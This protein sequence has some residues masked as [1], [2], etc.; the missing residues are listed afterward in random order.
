MSFNSHLKKSVW[1]TRIA[2]ITPI[3][4]PL[5]N[6]RVSIEG[7]S[8]LMR[9]GTM[10]PNIESPQCCHPPGSSVLG[11][12]DPRRTET[13]ARQSSTSRLPEPTPVTVYRAVPQVP[14]PLCS[15]MWLH[16]CSLNNIWP[17]P[18]YPPSLQFRVPYTYVF[19]HLYILGCMTFARI[20]SSA[21]QK[22]L[23]YISKHY[24]C[25]LRRALELDI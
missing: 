22:W 1:S 4:N 2:R 9:R 25:F 6:C 20:T 23:F 11:S 10:C 16:K 7:K 15:S 21:Y 8:G 3:W 14:P 18:N 24:Q 12:P 17:N 19:M 5:T 13:F